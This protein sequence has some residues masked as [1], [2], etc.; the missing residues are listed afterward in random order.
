MLMK[1]LWSK[2]FSVV[3]FVLLLGFTAIAQER[4]KKVFYYPDGSKSS[5]GEMLNGKPVGYWKNYYPW[6]LLKSEGNRKNEKL[7]GTWKFYNVAEDLSKTI[8]Y[9]D[10]KKSGFIRSYD[11]SCYL[12]MEEQVVQDVKH[13]LEKK[14]Y[15]MPGRRVHWVTPYKEGVKDGLSKEFDPNGLLIT[16]ITY[17]HG[18]IKSKEKINRSDA[19]GKQG[20]WQEY[21]EGDL[22]KREMKYK[23]DLLH[24]YYKEYDRSGKMTTAILYLNGVVQEDQDLIAKL[25]MQ[26]TYYETGELEWERG[27]DKFGVEQGPHIKYNKKGEIESVEMFSGGKLLAKGKLNELGQRIGYWEEYH[28]NGKVK[29]KGK[30]KDGVKQGDWSYFFDNEKVEQKGRYTK[31][32]KPHG[33][34]VWYYKNG[35]ILR[36]ENFRK[37]LEDGQFV[38]YGEDGTVIAKGEFLDGNKEGFWFYELGDYREEGMYREDR[39]EGNW[40][41]YYGNGKLLFQGM[42]VD[43][44]EQGRHRYYY[45]TGILKRE[46]NYSVGEPEGTWKSYNAQGDLFLTTVYKDGKEYKLDSR[47]LKD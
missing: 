33:Y 2:N 32:G 27:F 23:N 19:L 42:Y 11:D 41:H 45:S 15:T 39:R 47:K 1:T 29:A 22:L 8:D 26:R 6:G 13:G 31:N 36:E 3:F 9:V 35:D 10:G 16:I 12:V 34:W 37:G 46:E 7:D 5:E 44:Y 38:E 24:G 18:F 25:E 20:I 28:A 21:Y 30:Y 43:G 4:E 17:R 40:K 14:F